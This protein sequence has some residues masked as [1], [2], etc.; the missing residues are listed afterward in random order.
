MVREMVSLRDCLPKHQG[1]S[2]AFPA[3]PPTPDAPC[4]LMYRLQKLKATALKALLAAIK[5]LDTW[6]GPIKSAAAAVSL[7]TDAAAP[8]GAAGPDGAEPNG[9]GEGE[10]AAQP[11]GREVRDKAGWH[12]AEVAHPAASRSMP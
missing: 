10:F 11:R 4:Q 9:S 7:T 3:L 5:S 1:L 6:A 2:C 8:G 12:A